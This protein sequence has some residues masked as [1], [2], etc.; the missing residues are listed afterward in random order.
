MPI[1][2]KPIDSGIKAIYDVKE[3]DLEGTPEEVCKR[4]YISTSDYEDFIEFYEDNKEDNVIYLFRY[5]QNEYF[6][7]EA[8]LLKTGLVNGQNG[9]R[10]EFFGTGIDTNAYFFKGTVNLDFDIIQLT[11][12]LK[13]KETVIP[14]VA[15]PIDVFH[16]ATPPPFSTR[17]VNYIW[18]LVVGAVAFV[19]VLIIIFSK[20]R[21]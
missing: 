13:G 5:Q 4:L 21:K 16:E 9:V 18:V 8:S 11:F 20:G 15:D 19:L 10:K 17:D 1:W 3:E 12:N 2:L 6:A 14:V 7:Q